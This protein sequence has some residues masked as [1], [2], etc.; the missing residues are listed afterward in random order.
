MF[1]PETIIIS[2]Q[3]NTIDKAA[4]ACRTH[5]PRRQPR[6]VDLNGY[7]LSYYVKGDLKKKPPFDAS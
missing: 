5:D 1:S 3:N 7:C 4:S 6:L 2:V